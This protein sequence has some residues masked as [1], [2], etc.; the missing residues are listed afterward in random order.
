MAIVYSFLLLCSI[1]LYELNTIYLSSLSLRGIWIFLILTI[2]NKTN[3]NILGMSLGGHI[4]S[5]LL[6]IHL[7]IEFLS[8]IFS[9][10]GYCENVLQSTGTNL[11]SHQWSLR[12]QIA[13]DSQY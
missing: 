7:G 2:M 3:M 1:L 10:S 8:Y 9:S 6:V 11:C 4:H 12:V 5:L 13:L